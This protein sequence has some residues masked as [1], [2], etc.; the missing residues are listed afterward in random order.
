MLPTVLGCAPTYY[1]FWR[2]GQQALLRGDYAQARAFLIE[3]ERRRP[4]QVENLHDLGV[5]GMMIARDKFEQMNYAAAQR[6]LDQSIEY[7]TS[8]IEDVPGHQPSLEGKNR[9]LELKG[10]FDEALQH[11]E[12]T[13][14]FVGPSARQYVF[15]AR[16]MEERGDKDAA[17]T[18]YR[19]AVA[20][21]PNNKEGHVA[22]ARFLIREHHEPAAIPHLQEAH[23]LD[24][25]D[26][27]VTEQLVSRGVLPRVASGTAR[28]AASP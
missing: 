12:W 25:K 3:C 8:A 14:A 4:R 5:C 11:A 2:D 23:R 6:E 9:A 16:E 28:T 22:L 21:E 19:Q 15:L 27:W 13:V 10:Q 1:E 7:F 24:P 26:A 17:L 18:R 20:M